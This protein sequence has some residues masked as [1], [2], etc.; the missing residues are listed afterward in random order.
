MRTRKPQV[1]ATAVS[2]LLAGVCA[3]LLPTAGAGASAAENEAAAILQATGVKGGLIVHVGCGGPGWPGLTA[4]L[5]ATDSYVVHGLARDRAHVKKA[6]SHIQALGVYGPVSAGLWDGKELPYE[7]DMV[8]LVVVP[9]AGAVDMREVMRVL[10]PQ[11]VAYVCRAGAWHKTVKPRVPQMDEWTHYLHDAS[12]NAVSS[13]R[14]VAPPRQLRWLGSPRWV[15][16]HDYMASL[17]A[18]VS[19]GGRLFYI[20]DEGATCS[21]QYPARWAVIARDA[22]NGTVL[23]KRPIAKWHPTMW[24]GKH[25]PAQLPR[26]LVAHG[27]RVYVPLGTQVP[28]TALDAATGKTIRTYRQTT[29][30]EEILFRDGTLYVVVNPNP[31]DFA[32]TSAAALLHRSGEPALKSFARYRPPAGK[33]KGAQPFEDVT[34][35]R[36]LLAIDAETGRVKWTCESTFL[37]LTLAVDDGRAYFHDGRRVICLDRGSGKRLW[38][39]EP[40]ERNMRMHAGFS[41]TLVVHDGVVLFSG[42]ENM[43]FGRGAKDTMT[44]LDA[45]TGRKLWTAPHPPSGYTSPEDTFVVNGLVWTAPTTNRNDTGAFT[46]RDLRTG[47]VRASFPADDGQHMPHHRCHRAKAT[48]RFFLMSRTG[49]EFVDPVAKHWERHDW[50]RGSCQYGIM[51]ANGL[52]YAPPH[53]CSCYVESKLDGLCAL[54]ATRASKAARQPGKTGTRLTRGDATPQSAIHTPQSEDWPTYRGNPQRSGAART[55]VPAKLKPRWQ[56]R[57]G[58]RLSAVSLA[59]GRLLVASVDTHTVHALDADSG[60]EAWRFTAGGRV[61]SPPTLW[62]GLALFGSADGCVYCLRI[63]DGALVWRFRAVP[64][65]R[66]IMALGQLESQ[67]PIHGSV[68]IRAGVVHFVAGRSMFLDGGLRY[69]RLDAATGKMLSE[70]VMDDRDPKTGRTLDA[71]VRWP[72]MP[73]ALPDVLSCDG[74]HIY[75][76]R[77]LFDFEGRRLART[78]PHLYSPTGYLDGGAWW[79]RTYWVYGPAFG[80]GTGYKGPAQRGPAGRI[81]VMDDDNVYGFAAKPPH[82]YR[83]WTMGWFEYQ[84]FRMKKVPAKTPSPPGQDIHFLRRKSGQP[85]QWPGYTWKR[86]VPCLVRAMVLCGQ[87]LFIAGAPRILDE[88]KSMAA[89][90]DPAIRKA[91]EEQ[92]AAFAGRRGGLLLAVSATDGRTLSRCE[93]TSPPAWDA[94]AAAGGRLYLS[95]LDGSVL[96]LQGD[97]P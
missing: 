67:W 71:K 36:N 32:E 51:P 7:D 77:Q 29:A 55:T 76:R 47:Q 44:A 2:L 21:M 91:A 9:D 64:A 52:I 87:T 46:G 10:V 61:D 42:A 92:E 66:R 70:N 16:H 81:V 56:T 95:T 35:K 96:C 28:L 19:A 25:G 24:P 80:Y 30:T 83:G 69:L 75:M 26:R 79:H 50:V 48:E 49:I 93:L 27:N 4:Q 14:L 15:R 3:L 40:I 41:A 82:L 94:M 73:V 78:A 11:G 20:F 84:L 6:R 53:S 54:T 18:M 22:F 13:D 58:G 74:S 5:R 72:D 45:R 38:A 12:N 23:W 85:K 31:T 68:L 17:S 59:G 43:Q 34:G 39:S 1:A 88:R 60:K 97:Q 62:R 57:L 89:P 8:N 86:D 90:D 33:P 65:D 37:Q 63:S